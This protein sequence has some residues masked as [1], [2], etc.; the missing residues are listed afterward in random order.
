MVECARS[1]KEQQISEYRCSDLDEGTTSYYGFLRING[2]WYIMRVTSTAIR[3]ASGT[4]G[5]AT[6]WTGRAALSYNY[7]DQIF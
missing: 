2:Y 3:Y 5:Y 6:A 7:F 4:G 1:D